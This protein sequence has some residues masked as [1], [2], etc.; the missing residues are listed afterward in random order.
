MFL[1]KSLPGG[2]F[3]SWCNYM[4]LYL[5]NCHPTFW[6]YSLLFICCVWLFSLIS[7]FAICHKKASIKHKAYRDTSS[8]VRRW[9]IFFLINGGGLFQYEILVHLYGLTNNKMER[10]INMAWQWSEIFILR[11]WYFYQDLHLRL[12]LYFKSIGPIWSLKF[13]K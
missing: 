13:F 5:V 3:K 2:S 4:S 9:A 8:F 7:G 10:T 12:N 6:S 1:K 11:P